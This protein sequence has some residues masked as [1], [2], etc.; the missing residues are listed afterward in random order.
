[1]VQMPSLLSRVAPFFFSDVVLKLAVARRCTL[2]VNRP[3]VGYRNGLARYVY[4][5]T[6]STPSHYPDP[7]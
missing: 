5:P 1:M 4:I 2:L 3:I 6:T 7:P